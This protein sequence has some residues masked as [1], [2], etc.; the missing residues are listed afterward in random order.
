LRVQADPFRVRQVLLNLLSNAV[1]FTERG[2]VS[3][4]CA[5]A[6]A[7]GQRVRF[8]VRDTGIGI[9]DTSHLFDAFTQAD[10]STTRRFGGTGLGLS[11]C[12]R[13]VERMGGQLGVH[14]T[15][16]VGSC[17]WAELPLPST[18][19]NSVPSPAAVTSTAPRATA[20]QAARPQPPRLA[21]VADDNAVNRLVATKLLDRLGWNVECVADGRAAV[22]VARTKRFDVI[23]MDCQMPELDGYEAARIILA[24]VRP[25][26]PIVALT[27]TVLTDE[28]KRCAAIGMIDCLAKPVT[29]AALDAVLSRCAASEAQPQPTSKAA[30]Q[31]A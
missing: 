22:E 3:L 14:S 12:K 19:A 27:A 29:L 24:E 16:G 25:A 20:H 7:I 26:P 21:L 10:A 23:L 1:K 2:S 15:L 28:A 31:S 9:D 4:I 5:A 11:I 13:L 30:A 17:F 6:D 18:D 8:Q